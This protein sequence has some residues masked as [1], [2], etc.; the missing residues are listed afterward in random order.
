MNNNE[1]IGGLE[2]RAAHKSF[3]ALFYTRCFQYNPQKM[4]I[5]HRI[6]RQ[7]FVLLLATVT[8]QSSVRGGSSTAVV[9]RPLQAGNSKTVQPRQRLF[10]RN[11]FVN[12]TVRES[13]SSN[14]TANT[15]VAGAQSTQAFGTSDT[16]T[17]D[18]LQSPDGSP[19]QPL[20]RSFTELFYGNQSST[21]TDE[22]SANNIG[23]SMIKDDGVSLQN[24]SSKPT[25][26]SDKSPQSSTKRPRFWSRLPNPIKCTQRLISGSENVTA[27][28]TEDVF[29]F[30][31]KRGAD[32]RKV[33]T[34]NTSSIPVNHLRLWPLPRRGKEKNDKQRDMSYSKWNPYQ[35]SKGTSSSVDTNTPSV[36]SSRADSSSSQGN[37]TAPDTTVNTTSTYVNTSK[38]TED[39]V[40]VNQTAAPNATDSTQPATTADANTTQASDS[41]LSPNA[42]PAYGSAPNSQIVY[43]DGRP[44]RVLRPG[45]RGGPPGSPRVPPSNALVVGEVAAVIV[46]TAMRLWFLTWLT[47]R[48]ATQEEEFQHI[49][50]FVWELVNDRYERDVR[51]LQ[52]VMSKPPLG[53]STS[54]WKNQHVKKQTT[55]QLPPRDLL[56]TFDKTVVVIPVEV[57]KSGEFDVPYLTSVI[58]FL[59]QQHRARFCGTQPSR[60]PS[61]PW[62]KGMWRRS[63]TKEIES[64]DQEILLP[65]PLEVVLL[66]NSPGGG[67][68]TY[69][70]AAAQVKRLAQE[71]GISLTACVDRYA[72]SGGYMIA[73]QAHKLVAAPFATVGSI[74]VIL[75]GLNFHQLARKYGISPIVVKAGASKNPITTYGAVTAK[76]EKEEAARLAKVH[77][78]FKKLVAEGRPILAH[79]IDSVADGSVFLGQEALDL[80]MVDHIQTSE[81]YIMDKVLAGYRVLRLHRSIKPKFSRRIHLNPLDVLPHIRSWLIKSGLMER[82]QDPNVLMTLTG[83]W[84]M[85]RHILMQY[86]NKEPG[87]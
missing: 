87:F 44:Y 69:G 45:S 55:V 14:S 53:V 30:S 37:T 58:S 3:V 15:T 18:T 67:V 16:S 82:L 64:K 36:D 63:N 24:H 83:L 77:V 70:L 48:L 5:S 1:R 17:P 81:E 60:T 10:F 65:K 52:S 22:S 74:G 20:Q 21:M 47:R 19:S 71:P 49:Q 72:A 62:W 12:E 73:S 43:M 85:G 51:A 75:E 23:T 25:G 34:T 9:E 59:I 26:D 50:Q 31:S 54:A 13:A 7:C 6:L 40:G 29:V 33:V 61:V 35:E 68:A 41:Q 84:Q 78:A 4:L 66:V 76:E 27:N 28:S 39:D 57:E 80:H 8:V 11:I 86:L 46:G 79:S 56:E 2:S 38:V 32:V 42:M